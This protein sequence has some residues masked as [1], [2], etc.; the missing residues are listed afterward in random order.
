MKPIDCRM[1]HGL[2]RPATI[3][4]WNTDYRTLEWRSATLVPAIPGSFESL[5]SLPVTIFLVRGRRWVCGLS[6][7]IRAYK[8]GDIL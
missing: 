6:R 4:S 3:L 7:A 1:V 2:P 8:I 5:T